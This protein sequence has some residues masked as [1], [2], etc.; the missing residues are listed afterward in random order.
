MAPTWEEV[1]TE[2][3]GKVN[4][5]K[6][7]VTQNRLQKAQTCEALYNIMIFEIYVSL[8]QY[9]K[10]TINQMIYMMSDDEINVMYRG[11]FM[12]HSSPTNQS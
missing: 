2:L 5:A 1:A 6:V 3:K 11:W 8:F 9:Q 4:V 12:Y 7:D 10:Q